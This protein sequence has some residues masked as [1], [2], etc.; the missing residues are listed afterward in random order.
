VKQI[1]GVKDQRHYTIYQL[2]EIR[3]LFDMIRDGVSYDA[4]ILTGV[5]GVHE[6]NSQQARTL[7]DRWH[8]RNI[9]EDDR[10]RGVDE[11]HD[12]LTVVLFHPNQM[13]LRMGYFRLTKQQLEYIADLQRLSVEIINKTWGDAK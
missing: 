12:F 3:E 8:M 1:A 7:L 4:L 10:K 2:D 13:A 9:S 5:N 11:E 6:D